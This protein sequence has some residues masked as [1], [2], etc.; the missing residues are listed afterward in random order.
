MS[1]QAKIIQA[2]LLNKIKRT[3]TIESF[4]FQPSERID[5]IPGQFLQ[6]IFDEENLLNR[7]LNKYLSFSSSPNK[8]YFEVT[9]RLS[10]SKFSQHLK[11]L[12][13]GDTVKIKAPFGNCI[14][15]D[16][17]KK[18]GFLIGGIGITPVI[19]IIEYIVERNLNTDV[20]LFYSNRSEQEIAFKGELDQWNK[21]NNIKIIYSITGCGPKDKA[22]PQGY[23]D[24]NMI[25]KTTGCDTDRIFYIFGP[26]A[27]VENM[28]S[29]CS[30]MGY[31]NT[32]V[33][34]ESFTGY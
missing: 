25:D 31:C 12:Q 10:D 6:V 3:P 32:N 16:D 26:P 7:E 21:K 14:F 22:C 23:I 28:K 27:M 15:K 30:D 4:R 13:E 11:K 33:K 19:S 24:K 5:F 34:T 29:V 9:K 8:S 18:I 17:Y 20:V 1:N 2:K